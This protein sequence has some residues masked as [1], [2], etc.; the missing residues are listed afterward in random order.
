ME[1]TLCVETCCSI[2]NQGVRLISVLGQI[3]ILNAL[4]GPVVPEFVFETCSQAVKYQFILKIDIIEQLSIP[5]R[6]M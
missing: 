6:V 4:K 1:N 5:P 2:L 3:K